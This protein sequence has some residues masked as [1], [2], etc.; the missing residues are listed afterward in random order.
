MTPRVSALIPCYEMAHTVA[1]AVE[2]ALT[3]QGDPLEVIVV[4]DGSRDDPAPAL[5]RFGARVR[6]IR[7]ENAGVAAARNRAAA[8]ARGEW[9]A[10]LDADDRWLPRKTRVS[11]EAAALRP[12]AGFVF[13]QA[14]GSGSDGRSALLGAPPVGL[15][16][17]GHV[18]VSLLRTG[19]LIP[20]LT[21]M[22]RRDAFVAVGGLDE[23]LRTGED[24]DLWIRLAERFEA[25]YVD[26]PVALYTMHEGGHVMG[27]LE[28]WAQA[29]DGIHAAVLA[30]HE[31]DESV[32]A[33]IAVGRAR[34]RLSRGR[35][36]LRRGNR[37]GAKADL[38][39]AA[40]CGEHRVEALRLLRHAR[41]PGPLYRGMQRAL[42]R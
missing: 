35:D 16:V 4:D 39:A 8:E 7:Q 31:G 12:G 1:T 11:L 18:L 9:L 14:L 10:F 6:L 13:G 29:I 25:A 42:R 37:H 32:A 30:R 36:R 26:D 38:R 34:V 33:A 5:A 15:P 20:M 27:D 23:S 19:N 17:E 22:V 24:Y 41:I 28:R 3:Q 21:G 40:E 2:S